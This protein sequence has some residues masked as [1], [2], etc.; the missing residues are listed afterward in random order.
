L[1][2][3][4]SFLGGNSNAKAL[5]G[6]DQCGN[7]P[8][9]PV[10]G[11]S[12]AGSLPSIQSSIAGSQPETYHTTVNG[13]SVDA[14]TNMNDIANTLTTAQMNNNGYNLNDATSLNGLVQ[15]IQ[16][17]PHATVVP[18]GSNESNVNLGNVSDLKVVVVDGD[19]TMNGDASGAGILVVKGQLTYSGNT[20]YTGIIMVIGKGIMVRSG[21]GNGTISGGVYVANTAGLDGIIGNADD[22]L[23]VSVL[24]TSGG[25]ASNIQ[26]CSW[27]YNN[28]INATSPPPTYAPLVVS[29]FRQIL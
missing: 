9:V 14:T 19:F 12:A 25:G 1:G 18:G 11:V 7:A 26:Y 29:S 17:L 5:N 8:S 20:S 10:V 4:A 13:V 23:G 3:S 15:S 6:D 2:N 28:A 16:D 22:A 24:N 27:A 21:G